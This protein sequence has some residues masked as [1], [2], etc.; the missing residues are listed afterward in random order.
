MRG[1]HEQL[2]EPVDVSI[3]ELRSLLILVPKN[4]KKAGESKDSG[5]DK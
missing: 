1:M 3:I 4:I 2:R 5:S